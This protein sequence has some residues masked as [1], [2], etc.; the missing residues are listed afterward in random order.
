MTTVQ[1]AALVPGRQSLQQ[2]PD[3]LTIYYDGLCPLCMAEIHF[4][5]ARNRKGL[6]SFV[7]ISNKE[8]AD[9]GHPVSCADAMSQIRGRLGSGQLLTGV[10]VFI[11]AY[12]RADLRLLAWLLSRA[13]TR[14]ILDLGYIWFA[15]YRQSISRV[16]GPPLLGLARRW[17]SGGK[18]RQD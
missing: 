14:P 5:T 4:L 2:S 7:D 15:R 3:L 10:P 1:G 16:I 18:E 8:F 9:A 17:S 13:W 12:R 11:E 6:L